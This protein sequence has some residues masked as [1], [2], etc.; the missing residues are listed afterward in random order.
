MNNIVLSKT[1]AL[2]FSLIVSVFSMTTVSGC[3]KDSSQSEGSDPVVNVL[4]RVVNNHILPIHVKNRAESAISKWKN[5]IVDSKPIL[6]CAGL[7]KPYGIDKKILALIIFDE[8]RDIV[9]FIITEKYLEPDGEKTELQE[10]YPAYVHDENI[11]AVDAYWF[12]VQIRDKKQ[13]KDEKLWKEYEDTNLEE[14]TKEN[15]REDTLPPIW[16]SIPEP[17]K[18]DV[19]VSVYDKAGHKSEPVKLLNRINENSKE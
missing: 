15:V 16:I 5:R 2:V 9:G 6:I 17:N 12:K 8:D 1:N 4:N 18:V 11:A 10:D 19:W 3:K 7:E 14:L 13:Q